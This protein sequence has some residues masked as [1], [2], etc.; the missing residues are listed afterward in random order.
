ML[1]ARSMPS[2]VTFISDP[3]RFFFADG[4]MYHPGPFI[5]AVEK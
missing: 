3:P 5:E 2:V 1:F 4:Q